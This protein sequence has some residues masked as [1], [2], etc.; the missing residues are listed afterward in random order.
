MATARVKTLRSYLKNETVL[1]KKLEPNHND[2][3]HLNV[4]LTTAK[5]SQLQPITKIIELRIIK[6]Q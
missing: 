1:I 6:H 3:F 2:S 5:S 4:F